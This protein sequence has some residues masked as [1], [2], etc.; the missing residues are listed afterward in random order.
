MCFTEG[1]VART[2]LPFVNSE[3]SPVASLGEGMIPRLSTQGMKALNKKSL[4]HFMLPPEEVFICLT[5]AK[6]IAWKIKKEGHPLDEFFPLGESSLQVSPWK[7]KKTDAYEQDDIDFFY[8]HIGTINALYKDDK[9]KPKSEQW[10]Y[11]DFDAELP[12]NAN[13][14]AVG[15]NGEGTTAVEATVATVPDSAAPFFTYD[16]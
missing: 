4:S 14:S 10:M 8:R 1:C 9:N 15:T 2:K 12:N 7:G 11:F 6:Y 13:D 5:L 16:N 3:G